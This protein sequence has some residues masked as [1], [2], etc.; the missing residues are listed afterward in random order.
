MTRLLVCVVAVA[1]L[2]GCNALTGPDEMI[3]LVKGVEVPDTVQSGQVFVVTVQT[4]GPNGCW[5]KARTNLSVSGLTA[6]IT[7]YDLKSSGYCT[8]ATV[9]M[10]HTAEVVFGQPGTGLVKVRGRNDSGTEVSVI[11]E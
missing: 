10:T 2:G 3:G 5:K 1:L 6:T 8:Q 9:E 4:A 7:P 11:V